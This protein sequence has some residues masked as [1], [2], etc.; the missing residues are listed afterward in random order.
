MKIYQVTL[1][2]FNILQMKRFYCETLE[3]PLI[4]DSNSHFSVMAGPSKLV[5]EHDTETPYYHLCLRTNTQY[6]DHMFQELLEKGLLMPDEN[7]K[8]S[9]FWQGKQA[10]FTDPDGN[11]LEI[12]ERPFHWGGEAPDSG[13][14]DI[15]EIG[16]PV[17]EINEMQNNLAPFIEDQ[18]K[19]GDERFAF[20][21]D[22]EGVLV[23]VKEGRNWYP[24][25][26]GA[27]IH[28]IKAVVSGRQ[29]GTFT[30]PDLPYEI[31]VRE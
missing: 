5:F 17:K 12:L 29:E 20:Y 28:P 7:G 19:S 8:F 10:Y 24:T 13:W 15:G 25:E 6:Y 18:Q 21:G 1:K 23:L 22:R 4:S 3:M 26:R 9:M 11:I 16:F 2:C 30:H 31:T 14:F 27:T